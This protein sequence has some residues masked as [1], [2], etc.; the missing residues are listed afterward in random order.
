MKTSLRSVSQFIHDESGPASVEYCFMIGFILLVCITA[1][2][3]LGQATHGY[4]LRMLA[5]MP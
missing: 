3:N 2:G 5:V 4:Y 1:I